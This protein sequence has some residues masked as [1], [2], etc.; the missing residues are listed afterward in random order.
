MES[1]AQDQHED[2]RPADQK[3]CHRQRNMGEQLFH[4]GNLSGLSLDFL[5]RRLAL[6]NTFQ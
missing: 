6:L 3:F 1:R 2:K 4:R 5:N